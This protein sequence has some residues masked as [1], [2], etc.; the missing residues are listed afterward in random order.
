[1]PIGLKLSPSTIPTFAR[2]PEITSGACAILF[3]PLTY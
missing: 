1:M 3:N 2:A